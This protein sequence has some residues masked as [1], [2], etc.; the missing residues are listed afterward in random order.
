MIISCG[1]LLYETE[2]EFEPYDNCD[3][4]EISDIRKIPIHSLAK[5]Q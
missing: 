2:N 3:M 5:I 4:F 1:L